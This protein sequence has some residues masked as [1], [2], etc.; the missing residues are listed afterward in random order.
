MRMKIKKMMTRVMKEMKV[1]THRMRNQKVR[2]SSERSVLHLRNHTMKNSRTLTI[3]MSCVMMKKMT[4]MSK[5]KN[6]PAWA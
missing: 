5:I 1:K 3:L 2:K 4:L 6:Q